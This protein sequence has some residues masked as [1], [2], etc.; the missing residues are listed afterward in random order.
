[1]NNIIYKTN[2]Y[3]MFNLL[4]GNRI[5]K[6]S[7]LRKLDKSIEKKY[8]ISPI[9]VNENYEII[10]GQHR[11]Y[12][13]REKKLPLYYFIV[14]GYGRNECEILNTVGTS[15]GS[16]DYLK[17]FVEL[18]YPNYILL[19]DFM[20]RNNEKL[21]ISRIFFTFTRGTD[22]TAKF[23]SGDF[24]IKDIEKTEIFYRWYLDFKDTEPFGKILFA[25]S[26]VLMF[27]HPE[28]N[29]ERMMQK[30]KY[31]GYKM[32]TRSYMIEYQQLFSDIYNY[33]ARKGDEVY[34]R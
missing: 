31:Q 33:K 18:E 29:H 23:K 12:I 24:E 28:Y 22:N 15:W 21:E 16:M 11:F 3:S 1:M 17:S 5:I 25:H 10:D 26:I 2:D 4:K 19:N 9:M 13:A 7:N 20:E 27:N 34:F 30:M 32:Q 14:D 8:L 6:P